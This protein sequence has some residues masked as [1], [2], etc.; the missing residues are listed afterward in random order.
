MKR[1]RRVHVV[2]SLLLAVML[3]YSIAPVRAEAAVSDRIRAEA[4]FHWG[5]FVTASATAAK[6][7]ADTP[8]HANLRQRKAAGSFVFTVVVLESVRMSNGLFGVGP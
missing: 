3:T 4:A 5:V 1:D 7:Y 8:G 2:V 6:T